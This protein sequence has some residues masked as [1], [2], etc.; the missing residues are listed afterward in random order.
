MKKLAAFIEK[1][2]IPRSARLDKSRS[3][4]KSD[5]QGPRAAF[6]ERL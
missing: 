1:R 6:A 4:W 5:R 2:Q 3:G